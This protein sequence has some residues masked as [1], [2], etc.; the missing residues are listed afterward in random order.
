MRQVA[1]RLAIFAALLILPLAA[2]CSSNDPPPAPASGEP[3]AQTSQDTPTTSRGPAATAVTTS[4]VTGEMS[5]AE[6]VKFAEPAIVRISTPSGVGSGV[7]VASDGYIVT[8]NHVIT[9]NSGSVSGTINVLLS[10]GSQYQARVVGRDSRSDLAV[11]K[12][13]ASGLK[14]LALGNLADVAVGQDV[15][16]IGYALDL[17]GGEGASFSVTRGIVS[18]KNR[19]IDEGST[20]LGAIQTDAAINHGNSGGPLLNLAGEVIGINTAIAPD[21]A[22]GGIATGIGFAVGSDTVRAVYDEIKAEGRV[23]RGLLGIRDFEALRPAQARALG[24]PADTGGVY[25][26]AAQD[27]ANGGPASAA[28]IRTKD[29][30]VRVGKSAVKNEGDLAVALIRYHPGEKVTVDVYRDGKLTT[31]EITLGTPAQ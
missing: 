14:P 18:A 10:D 5:T 17:S 28:G 24:L 22:T 23:N 11:L 27:I 6:L 15:V 8:N 21:Q 19:G 2:A 25:L 20:I 29:V 30:I 9:G 7:I 3:A 31:L 16:A 12:I 13:E 4:V 1:R 26:D